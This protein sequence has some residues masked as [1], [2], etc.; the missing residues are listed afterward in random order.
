MPV[1]RAMACPMP[2]E[3][4]GYADVILGQYLHVHDP[5]FRRNHMGAGVDNTHARQAIRAQFRGYFT[6]PAER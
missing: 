3:M 5:A 4:T 2:S 6:W 1:S